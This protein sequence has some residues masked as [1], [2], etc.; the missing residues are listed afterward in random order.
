MS[1][2]DRITLGGAARLHSEELEKRV[3][4]HLL[5]AI[6]KRSDITQR[7]ISQDLGIALGLA[8]TYFK[9][10]MKK[11]LIK[12]QQ[13]PPNRYAYFMTPRGFAEKSRL[14]AEFLSQ[15][16]NLFRIARTE[17]A[18]AAAYCIARQWHRVAFWGTGDLAEVALLSFRRDVEVVGFIDPSFPDDAFFDLPVHSSLA[19][20]GAVDAVVLT[21]LAAPQDAFD[22]A[23][24]A[25]G[26]ERVVAP[27]LLRVV[28]APPV[29]TD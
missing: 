7:S 17:Y 15:S 8:N 21:S 28:A 19:E 16:F 14:T 23:C 22:A 9:R 12:I 1:E 6:Q 5:S 10:C 24:A 25:I 13:L 2:Y 26:V 11:G 4:L 18:D 27:P 20:S 3:T 29:M